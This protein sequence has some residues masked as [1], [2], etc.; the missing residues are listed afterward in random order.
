MGSVMS[1]S[2]QLLMVSQQGNSDLMGSAMNY[3]A[4]LLVVSIR[5]QSA[6]KRRS[7]PDGDVPQQCA[8]LPAI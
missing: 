4:Q 5:G 8:F 6:K 3:P 7:F 1:D 2:A